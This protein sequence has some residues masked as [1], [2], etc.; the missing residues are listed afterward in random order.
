MTKPYSD[1]RQ[2]SAASNSS[3]QSGPK[4]RENPPDNTP[5]V[6]AGPSNTAAPSES[7]QAQVFDPSEGRNNRGQGTLISSSGRGPA[8]EHLL[9]EHSIKQEKKAAEKAERIAKIEARKAAVIS[10]PESAKAKRVIYDQKQKQQKSKAKLERDR[11][12]RQIELDKIERREKEERGRLLATAEAQKQVYAYDQSQNIKDVV[13]ERS[14]SGFAMTPESRSCALQVRLFDGSIIRQKFPCSSTLRDHV[15]EWVDESRSDGDAPYTFKHLLVPMPNRTLSVAEEEESL[16]KLG[17]MPS[18]TLI[19]VPIRN[20]IA[21]YSAH[22][23]YL[24][25]VLSAIYSVVILGVGMIA[26][27]LGVFL[28]LGQQTSR[29][30]E[31]L[32][33]E[34]ERERLNTEQIPS[35]TLSGDKVRTFRHQRNDQ[36]AHQ[37][38]NGNQVCLVILFES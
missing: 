16:L 19:L 6:V 26:S 9:S 12:V 25:R 31:G 5:I 38:Y 29:P 35:S 7:I 11:I 2:S 22:R 34:Q 23:G 32:N 10:N 36:D 13:T 3:S 15:R 17:M 18:S 24:P 27:A 21:A 8:D 37:L 1:S 14:L 4:V 33:E 28:G 30:S 20:Y